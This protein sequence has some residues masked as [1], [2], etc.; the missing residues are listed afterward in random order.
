[1]LNPMAGVVE[2]FRWA[3]LQPATHPD[4]VAIGASAVV[5]FVL[6]GSGLVFFDRAEK[7]FADTV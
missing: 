1:M 2:G 6:V 4:F 7:T 3:L 5:V